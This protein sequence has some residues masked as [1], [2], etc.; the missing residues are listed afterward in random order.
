VV[1]WFGRLGLPPT[2]LL[3]RCAAPTLRASLTIC[4][5]SVK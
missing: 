3:E 5:H 2:R 1:V 4:S